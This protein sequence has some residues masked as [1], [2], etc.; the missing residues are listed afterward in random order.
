MINK[1]KTHIKVFITK[2]LKFRANI[3]EPDGSKC[4][5]TVGGTEWKKG[6]GYKHRTEIFKKIYKII[7]CLVGRVNCLINK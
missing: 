6:K 3:V 7:D 1:E 2:S 4:E 5:V